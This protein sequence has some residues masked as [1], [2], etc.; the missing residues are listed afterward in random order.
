MA[1]PDRK[2]DQRISPDALVRVYPMGFTPDVKNRL[3]GFA[4]ETLGQ[5]GSFSEIGSELVLATKSLVTPHGEISDFFGKVN[6]LNEAI[7]AGVKAF[8]EE[9]DF[10][11]HALR[12]E[13]ELAVIFAKVSRNPGSFEEVARSVTEEGAAQ[14]HQ[15]WVVSVEGYGHA[16]VAEH[17]IIHMAVENVPSLDGDEITDNRLGSFTEFSARFK[18]RQNVGYFTPE[19]VSAH[20]D[21]SRKW[22]EVHQ[23]LFQ[24]HDDLMEKGKVYVNTEEAKGKH[25]QRKPSIKTVADQFKNIMPASRLTS[26][27][28]TMNA[29]EVENTVRK[30]LSSPHESVR[31]LGQLFKEQCLTVSPTLVKYAEKNEYLVATRNGI[32]TQIQDQRYQGYIPEIHEDGKLVDLL[33][34]DPRA[35]ARFVAA[36]LYSLPR[37]G[38]YRDLLAKAENLNENQM[39][40]MVSILLGNLSKWDVPIRQLEFCGDY[41]VE[42]QGMTYGD[43]REYKRHRIQSYQV[44]D[45][46][47]K[48]G[49]MIPP[50]A[51]EMDDSKDP[52]FHGSV[53][54]VKRAMGKVEE[55]FREVQSVD[56]FA[57]Q[58]LVTRLHYRP[59]I[60]K[61]NLREAFHLVN[62]RTG[63]TAHPF[64]RRLMW[65]LFDEIKRVHP[66]IMEH[67][68]LKVESEGRPDRNFHWTY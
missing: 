64:I 8:Q 10:V 33:D 51:Y 14:F 26:I 4:Q 27:A 52:Q 22:E 44:K 45:L 18:G 62:L 25:P 53:D 29:R 34:Y 49:Y 40:Q 6:G 15:K 9:V 58:Y 13:E 68:R 35:D 63:P 43:W 3:V 48:W 5:L 12:T 30:M 47:V 16:S 46:D 28:V 37:A 1:L 54:A 67:L 17:A 7:Q 32:S 19:S 41:L 42:Y 21:L 65:P 60:A 57:A 31:K 23:F 50:L 36:A 11:T 59:A 2:V 20:P 66:V 56:P 55:L 61:F 38:S 24:T 39:K